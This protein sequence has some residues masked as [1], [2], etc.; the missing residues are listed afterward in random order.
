MAEN[1]VA[2]PSRRAILGAG[3]TGVLGLALA[4]TARAQQDGKVEKAAVMYQDSPKDG[5]K[6][7]MC[8]NFQRPNACKVVAGEI[9]PEG[10]CGAY[11][12]KS[13]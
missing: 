6:C 10:W 1:E 2:K 13:T 5:Q 7:S 4:Q 8:V 11:A 9:S 3:V 12:P